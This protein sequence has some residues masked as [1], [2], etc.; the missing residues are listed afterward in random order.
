MRIEGRTF[1]YVV[2]KEEKGRYT[3]QCIDSPQVH[4]EGE[5]LAEVEKNMRDALNLT[6]DYFRES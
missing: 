6:T 2:S 4:A 3:A 5:T 1:A